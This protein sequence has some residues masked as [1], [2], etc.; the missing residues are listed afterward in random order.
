L[1]ETENDIVAIRKCI[2][3]KDA[4]ALADVFHKLAGRFGQLGITGFTDELRSREIAIRN[5]Q[6]ADAAM[7]G[8]Q[9]VLAQLASVTHAISLAAQ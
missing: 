3:T 9:Q 5:G 8:M 1:M 7:A 6:D 4:G 2:D